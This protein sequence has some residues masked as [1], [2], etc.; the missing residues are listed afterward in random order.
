MSRNKVNWSRP[1]FKTQGRTVESINGSDLA[2]C[3]AAGN[4]RRSRRKAKLSFGSR[5]KSWLPSSG[6]GRPRRGASH[7]RDS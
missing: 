5:P 2:P 6:P 4:G 7:E 1:R 3:W